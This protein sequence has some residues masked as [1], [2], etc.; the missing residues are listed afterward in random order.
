GSV[1]SL[2]DLGLSFDSSGNLEFDSS[3]LDGDNSQ[4]VLNFLG[5]TST[6]GF[7]QAANNAL[8]SI[9]DSTTGMLADAT[10][11]MTSELSQIGTQISNQETS[12]SKLQQTLTTQMAATDAAISSLEQQVTEITDLFTTMQ[13]DSKSVTG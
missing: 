12:I 10:Q 5:S 9:T 13:Q 6:T 8:N 11:T 7:L 2:A 3:V 4:D 1:N